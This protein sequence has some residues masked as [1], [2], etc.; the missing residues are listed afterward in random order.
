[1]SVRN[2]RNTCVIGLHWG[3]EGKGK[4]VDLL[5][6]DFDVVVRF[7]GGANA[8]HTIVVGGEK[9]ALHQLPSGIIRPDVISGSLSPTGSAS[10]PRRRSK[11]RSVSRGG[12]KYFFGGRMVGRCSS[13]ISRASRTRA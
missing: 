10:G 4:V 13:A 11:R 6:S 5:V 12:R 3:D 1:M 2:L 8:G 7:A 9:F